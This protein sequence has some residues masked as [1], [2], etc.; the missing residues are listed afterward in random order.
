MAL[1]AGAYLAAN[2]GRV[3]PAG[4]MARALSVSQAHL[5]KVLERLARAGLVRPAR[6]PKGGFV[7]ARAPERITLRNIFEAIEGRM[8]PIKCLMKQPVCAK[9]GCLLGT[10]LLELNCR[11]IEY[12]TKTTLAAPKAKGRKNKNA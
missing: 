1:H 4:E 2:P 10:L 6:G 8:T 12:L 9:R 5:V 11:T 3:C 7:L